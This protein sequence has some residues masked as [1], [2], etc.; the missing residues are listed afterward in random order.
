MKITCH[1]LVVAFCFASGDSEL[2]PESIYR[3]SL[4][5]FL[6]HLVFSVMLSDKSIVILFVLLACAVPLLAQ[7]SCGSGLCYN[8]VCQ[9]N[10]C[11]CSSGECG[12][13]VSL[14]VSHESAQA[15]PALTAT[16][17]RCVLFRRSSSIP[18]THL[19]SSVLFVSS[20]TKGMLTA[21]CVGTSTCQHGGRCI[22]PAT[23]DC[24]GTGYNGTLC[25]YRTRLSLSF[26]RSAFAFFVRSFCLLFCLLTRG[27]F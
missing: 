14:C 3:H 10:N 24:S 20:L 19:L 6:L 16:R 27:C 2:A 18:R 4:R 25:Q 22:L 8:G 12:P 26:G 17:V 13:W 1:H 7:T 5:Q 9:T 23:C 21:L 11:M 15:G